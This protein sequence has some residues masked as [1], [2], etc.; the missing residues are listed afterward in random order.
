MRVECFAVLASQRNHPFIHSR[1]HLM[2]CAHNS[3]EARIRLGPHG[4]SWCQL[5]HALTCCGMVTKRARKTTA[6]SALGMRHRPR[7]TKARRADPAADGAAALAPAAAAAAPHYHA[8]ATHTP[9]EIKTAEHLSCYSFLAPRPRLSDTP[10]W[11]ALRT[12]RPQQP[13]RRCL[14]AARPS[15]LQR[16][17]ARRA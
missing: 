2:L 12:E 1:V 11:F 16:Q 10:A 17:V 5:I 9:E 6:V 7:R 14:A 3:Q 4:A 13:R 15:A 8:V